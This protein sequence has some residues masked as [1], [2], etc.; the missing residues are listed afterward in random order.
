MS[1]VR[2]VDLGT[3]FEVPYQVR[4]TKPNQKLLKKIDYIFLKKNDLNFIIFI[5]K[6]KK[7]Y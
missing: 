4:R 6:K 2:K 7:F 5:L 3:K 1:D